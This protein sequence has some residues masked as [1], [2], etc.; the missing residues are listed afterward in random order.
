MLRVSFALVTALL[1]AGG[2]LLALAG[3]RALAQQAAARAQASVQAGAPARDRL[4]VVTS[5]RPIG[6]LI[7]N[8]GGDRVEVIAI[9]PSG[10]EPEEYDPTPADALAVSRGRVFFA[11]GLGLEAYLDTLV[12]SAG[13]AELEVVTLS[14]GLPTIAGFGQG[15]DRGGN[16]HLWLDPQNAISYV[17]VI[18]A[19]LGRVDPAGASVYD[20]NAAA[21]TAQLY[22][23]DRAIQEQVSA[24]PADRRVLVTTHDAYPYFAGRYGF[25][26]LAVVS[27]NPGSDPSAQEYAELVKAV[28]A[29][30]VKAI[31]G[32]VGFSD[33]MISLLAQDTGATFVGDLYTDTLGDSAPTDTYLGA[34]RNN[35]ETIVGALQ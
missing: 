16:P 27:A 11:N 25:T 1:L 34:M 30:G 12:E 4:H 9:V 5:I 24:L 33:R 35:A 32:E 20:A 28:R 3:P 6:D 26:Y 7:Q 14:E 8:V 2:S 13:N 22:D 18:R 31:F 10:G 15:A 23:L 19:T 17:E 21:Y 29:S